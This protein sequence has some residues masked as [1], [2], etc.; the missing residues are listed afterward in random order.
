[1]TTAPVLK[2]AWDRYL[3]TLDEMRVLVEASPQFAA[4]PEQRVK[5]YHVF[6]EMQAMAYNF[7]VAPRMAH[8]RINRNTSWQTELYT[9]GGNGPDFLYGT[10]FLD[11]AQ[12]YRLD[13]CI[14]DSRLL[15]AQLN[16]KLPGC[17]GAKMLRNF[18]FSDFQIG[19]DGGFS[20]LISARPQDGN[21][22]QLDPDSDYQWMLFRPT[23]ETWDASPASLGIERISTGPDDRY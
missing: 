10:V 22:I 2:A 14:N 13:G 16:S 11:G 12:T 5:A 1:M 23:V 18:D 4:V 3:A 8:P 9:L 7:A 20:I 6:M 19:Q 21:W 17:P 15:I